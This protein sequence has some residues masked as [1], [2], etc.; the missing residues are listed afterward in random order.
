MTAT[1]LIAQCRARLYIQAA[2]IRLSAKYVIIYV[3][4]ELK[5]QPGNDIH[6]PA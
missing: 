3:M 4:T 1:C 5:K 2:I 6:V